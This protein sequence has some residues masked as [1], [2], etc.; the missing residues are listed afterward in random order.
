M[1]HLPLVYNPN[2]RKVEFRRGLTDKQKQWV[3]T[4]DGKPH[5]PVLDDNGQLIDLEIEEQ[6]Q[7]HHLHMINYFEK[8]RPETDP[9][10][11]ANLFYIGRQVHTA[12]HRDWILPLQEEYNYYMPH[13]SFQQYLKLETW[14]GKRAFWL[15][16]FDDTLNSMAIINSVNA[17]EDMPFSTR[18]RDDINEMYPHIPLDFVERYN[19]LK[20]YYEIY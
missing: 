15:Q 4:R 18:Y 5:F 13:M 10:Y 12:I 9:N 6:G 7:V 14:T 3:R 8:F 16:Q 20:R 11:P 2:Y 1:N 17:L 19:Y